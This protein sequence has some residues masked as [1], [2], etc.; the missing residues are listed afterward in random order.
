MGDEKKKET[1]KDET[2]KKVK[3]KVVGGATAAG[4]GASVLLGGLFDS[5]EELMQKNQNAYN[6][7]PA[8]VV[9]NIDLDEEDTDED[10]EGTEE[11]EEESI[12][13]F[14]KIKK[15]I[16]ELPAGVRAIVGVPLWAIGWVIIHLLSIA[17]EAVL[18]PVLGFL[19][20]WVL[21]GL[22]LVGVF[23]AAM[24]CA[25]PHLPLRKILR[26]KNILFLILGTVVLGVIDKI[27]PMFWSAYTGYRFLIMLGGGLIVLCAVGIPFIIK[28]VRTEKQEKLLAEE[29]EKASLKEQLIENTLDLVKKAE[30]RVGLEDIPMISSSGKNRP[31]S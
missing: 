17:W 27:I 3:K 2:L 21:A 7:Q 20:K 31:K 6:T 15:K 29:A 26:P 18:A 16:L 1:S 10:N 24:K 22:A 14:A 23:A 8:P 9:L 30:Q 4:L 11:T 5:P 19:L 13:V 12:G 25:F 28:Q